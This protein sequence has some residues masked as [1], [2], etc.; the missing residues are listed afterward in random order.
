MFHSGEMRWFF[1]G[2]PPHEARDWFENRGCGRS[3]PARTDNYLVL[4]GCRTA[5]VKLRGGRL[6]IKARTGAP[7]AADYANG[8]S[9]Y[10]DTWVKWSSPTGD[11]DYLGKLLLRAEDRWLSV[12]K[13]RYL[14][15][16]SLVAQEPEEVEPGGE[17]LPRGCQVELTTIR[18][19]PTDGD[20]TLA[21][22]WWSLSFEAFNDPLTILEDLD[23]AIEYFFRDAPP[24]GL[25]RDSSMSYPVWL[26]TAPDA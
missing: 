23:R 10:R 3:E 9:G 25:G 19:W 12:E 22:P 2:E 4:P 1:R 24:I 6:E 17:W 8:I 13:Q 26:D 16:V 5:G 21:A 14:R 7:E 15:L 11:S 20:A 18:T